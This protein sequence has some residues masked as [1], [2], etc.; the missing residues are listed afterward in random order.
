MK[1]QNLIPVF[2][3][4]DDNYVPFL[5]VALESIN[6]NAAKDNIYHFYVL[7]SGTISLVNQ[8]RIIKAHKNETTEIEF[9]DITEHVER[10]SER[11]HTRDYYSKS[12]YYRLFI[13]NLY[14]E[15]DKVLY[16]DSDIV[17][18]G[19][20]SNLYHVELGNNLVGAIT[21]GAVS[22]VKPFQDY[23]EKRVG[24][25]HHS[26]YFNAGILLMNTK[27]L[28]E[29]NF[30][31]LFFSLLKKVTFTVAQDQDYLNAICRDKVTYIDKAWNQMPIDYQ[32]YKDGK[33]Y[34]V[35]FNLSFKPWQIDG[36]PY[37]EMFWES[38]K[39]SPYYQ[40]ILKIKAN[41]SPE[42]QKKS[43]KETEELIKR[44]LEESLELEKNFMVDS[45]IKSVHALMK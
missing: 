41:Y 19:D 14:P 8:N 32:D 38:A 35:H 4:C 44:A 9:V 36:V 16:L 30:E 18:G 34:L 39:K 45:E 6:K 1:N 26:K 25:A 15:F 24:V 22:Q 28:R 27:R 23:V 2:F 12:T 37:E 33:P 17:V 42:L 40:D 5:S 3:S 10:I 7:H 43:A 21:D 20:I 13:P 11:L 31:E 29:I